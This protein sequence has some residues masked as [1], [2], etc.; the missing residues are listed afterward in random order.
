MPEIWKRFW[1]RTQKKLL[2]SLQSPRLRS[3]KMWKRFWR[4]KNDAPGSMEAW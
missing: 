3:R 2:M 4:E 1:R